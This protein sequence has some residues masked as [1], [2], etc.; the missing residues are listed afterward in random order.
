MNI[1]ESE[2]WNC[3]HWKV[4]QYRNRID[5]DQGFYRFKLT[6][7]IDYINNSCISKSKDKGSK[8]NK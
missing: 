5:K 3:I 8:L 2:C 1:E 4:C 7:C 6:N